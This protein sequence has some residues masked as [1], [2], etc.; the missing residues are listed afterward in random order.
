MALQ[1]RLQRSSEA[2]TNHPELFAHIKQDSKRGD[3]QESG[4]QLQNN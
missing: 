2:I 4:C 1:A 3:E